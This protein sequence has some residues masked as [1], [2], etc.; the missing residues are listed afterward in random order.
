VEGPTIVYGDNRS[1]VLN[2]S[3][4]ESTLKKKH[5]LCSVQYI[6]QASASSV[7]SLRSI[8]SKKN[9]SDCMTKSL[10]PH[11]LHNLVKPILFSK[12][13]NDITSH[14]LGES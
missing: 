7:V 4:P 8:S 9:I 5:H 14:M 12:D 10:P 13:D 3:K 6:R 11:L 2:G 1:V